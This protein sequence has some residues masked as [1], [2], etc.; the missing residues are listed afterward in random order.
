MPSMVWEL[1]RKGF[2][3]VGGMCEG[4]AG[5]VLSWWGDGS[6]G[7]LLGGPSCS[8]CCCAELA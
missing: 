1:L 6:W 3:A 7:Q 8:S 4:A 2:G 5:M